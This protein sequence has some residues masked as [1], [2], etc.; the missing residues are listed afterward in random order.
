MA[1][2][3][4]W[5]QDPSLVPPPREQS[6]AVI[7]QESVPASEVRWL[8]IGGWWS[9][10]C[11]VVGVPTVTVGVDGPCHVIEIES[12]LKLPLSILPPLNAFG[13]KSH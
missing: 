6:F 9:V 1:A 13:L 8:G 11:V 4:D 12:P 3:T 5:H 10:C 2:D 7:N